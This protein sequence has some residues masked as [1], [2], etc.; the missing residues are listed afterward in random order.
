[1]LLLALRVTAVWTSTD[2]L[3]TEAISCRST[4]RTIQTC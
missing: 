1:M 4:G 2:V 3:Q